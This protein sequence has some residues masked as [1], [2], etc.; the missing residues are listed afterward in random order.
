MF[1]NFF[2]GGSASGTPGAGSF[3]SNFEVKEPAFASSS[4]GGFGKGVFTLHEGVSKQSGKRVSVFVCEG[5]NVDLAK[6]ALKRLK[7]LR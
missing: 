2:K 4:G 6:A 7:T 3:S 5:Q 1:S